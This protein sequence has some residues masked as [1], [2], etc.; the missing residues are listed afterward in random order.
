MKNKQSLRLR[1]RWLLLLF[2]VVLGAGLRLFMLSKLPP[3][4]NWDEVSHGYNAYSILKTGKDEWGVRFPLANFRAYGDYPLPL[5]LY[6][7]IPFIAVL[8]L[9]EFAIRFPHAILGILTIIATYF[10][11]NGLT[12]K[13]SIALLSALLIAIDP[14]TVFTSRFVLQSNLAIFFLT[15]SGAFFFNRQKSRWFLPLSIISS[16]LTLYSYNTTRIF[17]P[18]VFLVAFVIYRKEIW[19]SFKRYKALFFG[20]LFI[21]I[22]F[23]GPIPFI[24][25]NPEARARS[26]VVFILDQGAINKINE[27]RTQSKFPSFVSKLIYNKPVYFVENFVVNYFDYFTPQFLFLK[28]GTQYQFSV[29]NHG[30]SY[31]INLPFFYIGLIVLVLKARKDK[32]YQLILAWLL[33]APIPAAITQE[34]FA[35]LRSSVL[36]PLPEILSTLGLFAALDWIKRNN[37]LKKAVSVLIVLYFVILASQFENY[38]TKYID[39]YRKNYSWSWQYGYKEVVSFAK[40]NYSKYDKII[41]TKKYG[42]PHE[43]FLFFWPWS[44]QK[45]MSDPNLIRFFQSGWYWVD[46]FDKFYFVNDWQ[47]KDLITESKIKIDCKGQRCLLITSPSNFPS[48]WKKL[49]TINFLDGRPAFEIYEN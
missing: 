29:P 37:L 26:G 13:K 45:Y 32:N 12:K 49:D 6:L 30:L 14:W 48:G 43:F 9:G 41:V 18:L 11:V 21:F 22:L 4:L 40:N 16:G 34:K 27:Q 19:S 2:I 28:G 42:E 24:L 31:S 10:L 3:S 1:R 20:C 17:T 47:V 38:M 5:N 46:R 33:L 15:L 44:P 8:G 36:I 23:F 7:T 25:S 35:V 39:D